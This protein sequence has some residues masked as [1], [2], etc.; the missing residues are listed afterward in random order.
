MTFSLSPNK[1][2]F[3][4]SIHNC[5]LEMLRASNKAWC[6]QLFWL[7]L[8][9]I[10]FKKSYSICKIDLI[11][12]KFRGKQ[13]IWT[14]DIDLYPSGWA[15]EARYRLIIISSF[16]THHFTVRNTVWLSSIQFPPFKIMKNSII[17][18]KFSKS[19]WNTG[20]L[21]RTSRIFLCYL[22]LLA[23]I[24]FIYTNFHL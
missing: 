14:S 9:H 3:F 8:D 16:H 7:Y 22:H 5:F 1:R 17:T 19:M 20:F 6:N 2:R 21:L 11:L 23:F 18:L 10:I 13:R 15:P 4:F 12:S 24:V